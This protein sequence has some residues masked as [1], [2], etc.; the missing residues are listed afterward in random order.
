ME[1]NKKKKSLFSKKEVEAF[2]KAKK[3]MLH[4]VEMLWDDYA[5]TLEELRE[6]KSNRTK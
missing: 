1:S 4:K 6:V 2:K 5:L 3:E